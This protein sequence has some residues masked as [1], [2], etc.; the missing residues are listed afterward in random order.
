M[1]DRERG[2]GRDSAWAALRVRVSCRVAEMSY[3]TK[4]PT[5]VLAP[6]EPLTRTEAVPMMRVGY[7]ERRP[8]QVVYRGAFREW[9][10]DSVPILRAR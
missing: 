6:F 4:V 7:S 9:V 8:V 3:S 1:D 10:I 2:N 5:T